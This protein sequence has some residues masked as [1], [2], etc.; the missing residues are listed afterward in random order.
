MTLAFRP[1]QLHD[2]QQS[3]ATQR[4]NISS[5]NRRFSG[6]AAFPVWLSD[7]TRHP[8][9]TECEYVRAY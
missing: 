1:R 2:V 6:P 3:G 7:S 4:T 5:I 9:P 8:V